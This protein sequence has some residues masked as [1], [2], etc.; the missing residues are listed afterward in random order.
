MFIRR[1]LKFI[2]ENRRHN[3]NPQRQVEYQMLVAHH[4]SL[5]NLNLRLIQLLQMKVWRTQRPVECLRQ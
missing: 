1:Y 2:T 5:Q 3:Q 4:L